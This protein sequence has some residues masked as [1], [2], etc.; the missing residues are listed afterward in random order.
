MK[1]IIISATTLIFLMLMTN[2]TFFAGND[3]K[4]LLDKTVQ[5][6]PGKLLDLNTI[7]GDINITV[8]DRNEANVKIYGND[9]AEQSIV[10]TA[11]NSSEGI[12]VDGTKKENEKIKDVQVRIEVT[13]PV[14]Y[15]MK[16]NTGGGEV[17][18]TGSN[19]SINFNT[20]GGNVRIDKTV[21]DIDGS[22]AGG[23]VTISDARGKLKFSTSGGNISV[24]GAEGNIDISTA[25]GNISLSGSNGSIKASTA[26]G[27]ISLDYT[28]E[29]MGIDLSTAAGKI[30]AELPADFN[31]DADIS[32][33]VGKIKCDF[34]SA[35][36][37][38]L[39]SNLKTKFNSGGKLFKCSTAA[40]DIIINKK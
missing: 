13:L 39:F 36:T 11:D 14:S 27:N 6:E 20:A 10:F 1:K 26:G 34:A 17:V 8:S 28:G 40:G 7:A 22:T 32:T 29:N 35:E 25:G 12:K 15:N 23:N 2:T 37:S 30:K 9:N 19:G 18:V 38:K 16:M 21:G 4:L 33:M 31:A 24:S 5:T 3:L